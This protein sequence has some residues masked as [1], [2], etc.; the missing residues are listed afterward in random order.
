[1]AEILKP[2]LLMALAAGPAVSGSFPAPAIDV[3]PAP[4]RPPAPAV[5]AGGCYWGMQAVFESLRGVVS[6]TAG[7]AGVTPTEGKTRPPKVPKPVEAARI[8]YDPARISYGGL[9]EVFFAVAHDP[10]ELNRQGPDVGPQYRSAIFYSSEAQ[11]KV[12]AAYIAQLKEA[13]AFPYPIV[14]EVSP[15]AGFE[16]AGED[17]QHYVDRHPDSDYVMENDLP[18]LEALRRVFRDLVNR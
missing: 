9:L 11:R 3:V 2:L 15:L 7:Y 12:A 18:K 1:M 14:T 13:K 8:V 16:A 4:N 6:V 5:L 17:Q 10:T